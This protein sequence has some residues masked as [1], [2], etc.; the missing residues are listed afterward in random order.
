MQGYTVQFVQ[1][2]RA[3]DRSKIGVA[4]GND[5][6]DKNIPIAVVADYVGVTRMTVYSWFTGKFNPRGHNVELLKELI[7]DYVEPAIDQE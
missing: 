1:R 5:V 2:V 6:V 4:L 3:G 7:T